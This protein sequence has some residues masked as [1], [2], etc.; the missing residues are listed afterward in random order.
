MAPWTVRRKLIDDGSSY[1]K[2]LNKTRKELAISYIC[3]TSLTL[4]EIAYLIGFG[5]PT[6]FQRAFK[7]WTGIAPGQFKQTNGT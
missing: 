2:I 4:G 1:Q 6:A 3:H 7:R 5:S